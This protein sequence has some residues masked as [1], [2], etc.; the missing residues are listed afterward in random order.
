MFIAALFIIVSKRK[1]KIP[2]NSRIIMAKYTKWNS[3]ENIQTTTTHNDMVEFHK[4]DLRQ[5]GQR[6]GTH[7]CI[8]INF[9][10]S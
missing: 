10:N 9:K 4:C 8:S 5:S 7:F 6:K 1:L 3:D 2:I